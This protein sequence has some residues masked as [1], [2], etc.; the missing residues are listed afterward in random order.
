[1][2]CE[3]IVT[4]AT[5]FISLHDHMSVLWV[6]PVTKWILPLAK[7]VRIRWPKKPNTTPFQVFFGNETLLW[8]SC[9]KPIHQSHPST[10]VNNNST[11]CVQRHISLTGLI[12]IN[13]TGSLLS[14]SSLLLQHLIV[15]CLKTHHSRHQ[16]N[17]LPVLL[18]KEQLGKQGSTSYCERDYCFQKNPLHYCLLMEKCLST[19]QVPSMPLVQH[20]MNCL[21]LGINFFS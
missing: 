8:V 10:D 1:M 5:Q 3:C 2:H 14:K 18:W 4:G 17:W 6:L 12:L 11:A 16:E 20:C 7:E 21:V 9:K 19:Y 13:S 15:P